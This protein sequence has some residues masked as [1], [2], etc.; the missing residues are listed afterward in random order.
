MLRIVTVKL[1]VARRIKIKRIERFN[2]MTALKGEILPK[3][4]WNSIHRRW[5]HRTKS[6]AILQDDRCTCAEFD[7]GSNGD[8]ES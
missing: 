4:E 2:I 7:G 6:F 8:I 3:P 5:N 1:N